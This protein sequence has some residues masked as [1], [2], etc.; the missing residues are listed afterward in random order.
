VLDHLRAVEPASLGGVVLG[1]VVD[2]MA[3]GERQQLLGL[4]RDRL[5]P[6]GVLVVHSMSPAGWDADDAPP[7]ADLAPGR[8]LRPATWAHLLPSLGYAVT[9]HDGPSATDYLVVAVLDTIR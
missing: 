6:D 3:H 5:A 2:G 9:V 4:L 8:P 1:G 7:E